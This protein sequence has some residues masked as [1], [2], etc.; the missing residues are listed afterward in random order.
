MA[1]L[2]MLGV[3]MAPVLELGLLTVLGGWSG[4]AIGTGEAL[5]V[6]GAIQILRQ[7]IFYPLRFGG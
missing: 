5:T 7:L 4:T 1:L 3:A 2:G 6:G